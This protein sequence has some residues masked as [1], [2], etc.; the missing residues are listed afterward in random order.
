MKRYCTNC[1]A[2]IHSHVLVVNNLDFCRKSCVC[3]YLGHKGAI[4]PCEVCEPR[5]KSEKRKPQ[6]ASARKCARVRL[7]RSRMIVT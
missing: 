1:K 2:D 5:Q 4:H 6:K 7:G 3:T